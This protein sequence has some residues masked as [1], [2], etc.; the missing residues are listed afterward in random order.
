MR[1]FDLIWFHGA[2]MNWGSLID[3][4][5]NFKI[6][7]TPHSGYNF[8]NLGFLRMVRR[9]SFLIDELKII[10]RSKYIHCITGK[11]YSFLKRIFPKKT[12]FLPNYIYDDSIKHIS[13]KKI[14]DFVYVG[15]LDPQKN[16]L[17][18]LQVMKNMNIKVDIFGFFWKSSKEKYKKNILSNKYFINS[19]KGELKHSEVK[20]CLKKYRY[21]ILPSKFDG[22]PVII[23]EAIESNI[24]PIIS[25]QI[26]LP[27][28]IDNYIPKIMIKDISQSMKSLEKYININ[29]ADYNEL[30]QKLKKILKIHLGSNV[31]D[32]LL[33]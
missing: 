22:L 15:R 21:L 11:E 33:N 30:L 23:F 14:G 10:K 18:L 17:F 6:I 12:L 28:Y 25:D 27:K 8:I 1:G 4:S 19:F 13:K 3:S 29:D 2:Y 32:N 26:L 20:K 31:L 16:I 9:I 24:I 5:R 7:Y